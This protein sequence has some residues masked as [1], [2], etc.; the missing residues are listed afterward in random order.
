MISAAQMAENHD[1]RVEPGHAQ[2]VYHY[3]AVCGTQIGALVWWA[4]LYRSQEGGEGDRD[5]LRLSDGEIF[6]LIG[7]SYSLP[8]IASGRKRLIQ[9]GILES[10]RGEN[11]TLEVRFQWQRMAQLLDEQTRP[12]AESLSRALANMKIF[13]SEERARIRAERPRQMPLLK[14]VDTDATPESL[15]KNFDSDAAGAPEGSLVTNLRSDSL[16]NLRVGSEIPADGPQETANPLSKSSKSS[17]EELAR[18]AL[19][20]QVA[21]A[22]EGVKLTRD[23]VTADPQTLRNLTRLIAALPPP[24]FE[25]GVKALTGRLRKYSRERRFSEIGWGVVYNDL[26]SDVNQLLKELPAEPEPPPLPFYYYDLPSLGAVHE[27]MALDD[28][29]VWRYPDR[30]ELLAKRRWMPQPIPCPVTAPDYRD[31]L[32]DWFLRTNTIPRKMPG[33]ESSSNGRSLSAAV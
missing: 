30:A 16:V 9:L 8:S 32:D 33:R 20:S 23:C 18:A 31:Q 12:I 5:W 4:L 11:N 21:E 17:E 24:A 25:V 22:T 14:N 29:E 26:A 13:R 2:L 10:R 27:Q 19:P 1:C 15:V 7:G 28:Q 3:V 6:V